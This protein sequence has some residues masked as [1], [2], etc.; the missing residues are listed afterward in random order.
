V[1]FT[2]IAGGKDWDQSFAGAGAVEGAAQI[3]KSIQDGDGLS[4]AANLG[5]TAMDTLAFFVNP[6]ET[7]ATTAIGWLIEH[8][9]FLDAF[10]DKTTGDPQAVQN[11]YETF[12]Q[13]A[14]DLDRAAAEQITAFGME[15]DTYRQGASQSAQAFE[16]RVGPRGEELKTL[17]L[18][19]LGL[20]DAM[21]LAA[22]RVATCRGVF[23]DLLAD[24][25][26]W[27]I[28]QG[29]LALAL[30]PYT[31]GGSLAALA[32]ETCISGARLAKDFAVKLGEL[33]RDLSALA[34]HLADLTDLI[35]KTV[36]KNYLPSVAKNLDDSVS[37]TAADAA[38]QQVAEHKPAEHRSNEFP[39]DLLPELPEPLH[40][41]PQPPK[42]QGPGLNAR[43]TTSG[44][45]DE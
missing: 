16:T 1:T 41:L 14:K 23:R 45:L 42:K 40:P 26:W 34:D 30:A 32:T 35:A 37:L 11:A 28:E 18:Q 36:W 22:I 6:T 7:L 8:I 5:T 10:L 9:S 12:Y 21:N 25:T 20:G 24:F 15:M 38:E 27:V 39:P 31:S 19:C 17:S 13:A 3:V 33:A 29:K 43:W 4:V 44:T 2:N